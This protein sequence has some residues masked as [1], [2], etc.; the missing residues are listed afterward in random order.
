MKIR[1][2]QWILYAKMNGICKETGNEIKIGDKILYIPKGRKHVYC[3]K[4]EAFKK[5]N[6]LKELHLTGFKI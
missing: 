5:A 4:S 1:V 2:N 3:E 6:S